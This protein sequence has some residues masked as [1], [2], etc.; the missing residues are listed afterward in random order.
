MAPLWARQRRL[1]RKVRRATR[2]V[3]DRTHAGAEEAII[4]RVTLMSS[5]LRA[6][7]PDIQLISHHRQLRT[8]ADSSTRLKM[9]RLTKLAEAEE[10]AREHRRSILQHSIAE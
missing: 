6:G 1:R 7:F 8:E 3:S 5:A 10:E 9:E 4:L 2:C